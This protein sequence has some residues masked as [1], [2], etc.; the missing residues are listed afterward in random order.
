MSAYTLFA[1]AVGTCGIAWGTAGIVGVQLPECNPSATLS[2]LLRKLGGDASPGLPP[3]DV[4]RTIDDMTAL[5]A[6]EHRDLRHARLDLTA[7]PEFFQRVYAIVRQ[8]PPG[9]TLSYGEV[10]TR[11]ADPAAA[12]TVGQAMARNPFPIIVPC[13]RVLAAHGKNGGFSAHGGVSTKLRLLAIE[14]A[15]TLSLP[16]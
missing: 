13:H 4:Q 1:T 12:R 2:R 11:C 3:S 8:I 6:G 16:W 14:G 5:L 9:Q 10:A 15:G 7:I